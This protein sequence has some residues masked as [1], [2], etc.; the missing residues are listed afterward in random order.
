MRQKAKRVFVV[1]ALVLAFS[2]TLTFPVFAGIRTT[3]LDSSSLEDVSLWNNLSNDVVVENGEL[4]FP[5]N[6]TQY[7]RFVSTNA[8]KTNTGLGYVASI[9]CKLQFTQLPENEKF[10]LAFGL[11]DIESGMGEAGNVEIVFSNNGGLKVEVVAYEEAGVPVVLS[12]AKAVGVSLNK[13]FKLNAEISENRVLKIKA[14]GKTVYSGNIPVTGEGRIGF[15]QTKDCGAKVSNILV[16]L[17][18]YDRPQNTDIYETFD[19]GTMNTAVL[20][21]RV[22]GIVKKNII[23]RRACI[24]EYNGNNVFMF[25]NCGSFYLGTVYSY[26]NFELSFDVP[27]FKVRAVKD[28]N[29]KEISVGTGN[30]VLSFG[31]PVT[32][33]LKYGYDDASGAIVFDQGIVYSYFDRTIKNKNPYWKEDAPFSVKLKV[34]DKH[35][36]VY[37]K[38]LNDTEYETMLEFDQPD[39]ASGKVHFWVPTWVNMAI[40]NFAVKNL[41]NDPNLIEVEYKAGTYT[42]EDYEYVPFERV[43]KD[44]AKQDGGIAANSSLY[45]YLMIPAVAVVCGVV[46]VVIGR[47]KAKKEA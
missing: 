22:I 10:I 34:V 47:K 8:A 46:L 12:S 19:N 11:S 3:V 7:T 38:E 32:D 33:T 35:V 29:G 5:N 39:V 44:S 20:S 23:N 25:E 28:E 36:T 21:S 26:S 42:C 30:F 27:Y 31:A 4:I 9:A 18:D 40:D 1:I 2:M 6:S 45:W 37:I 13:A 14:D 41:D 16:H 15:V 43:Y 24:E 17:G